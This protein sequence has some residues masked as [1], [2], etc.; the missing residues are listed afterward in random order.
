M[1]SIWQPHVRS[2]CEP[3]GPILTG[4]ACGFIS[5]A[6]GNAP[7]GSRKEDLNSADKGA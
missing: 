1:K 7:A 2:G 6:N 5:A 3:R 4:F